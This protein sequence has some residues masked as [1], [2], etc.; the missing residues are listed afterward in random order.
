M[1]RVSR[2]SASL[3]SEAVAPVEDFI[4]PTAR[5]ANIRAE[6]LATP[7]SICL[8]RPRLMEDFWSSE[9]GRR[10]AK[11]EHP[12]VHRALTLQY[13]FS[14]RKPRIYENELIIGNMTSKRIAANYYIEGGSINILED[15]FRLGKRTIPLKLSSLETVE[16]LLIGLRNS[17]K[18]VGAKALLKPGRLSYFLDFF[19]A[20]RHFV[21]E[22]AG[23][24]HQ[25][26]NYWMVVHE[27][28][29]SPYEDANLRLK[30][31]RLADGSPLD[32][33]QRAFFHSVII[34]IDGIRKMAENLA[35]EAENMAKR[36]GISEQRKAE[37]LESA[38]ACRLGSL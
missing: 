7:Y 22:E 15:F 8:E 3:T 19:R 2:F 4:P 23:I 35:V 36:P 29:R 6:L 38:S 33:D 18:S 16:L 24:G 10:S 31:G 14:H 1:I 30:E 5:I 26:G 27:G 28:L 20:K 9:E 37:L 34:T 25:V 32:A 13:I 12:L 11:V 21:T 17:F